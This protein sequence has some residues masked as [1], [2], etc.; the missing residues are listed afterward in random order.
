MI[1]FYCKN[2]KDQS[3]TFRVWR[4]IIS[5]MRAKCFGSAKNGKFSVEA[6]MLS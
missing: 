4:V 3:D 2:T 5:I 6:N 1:K